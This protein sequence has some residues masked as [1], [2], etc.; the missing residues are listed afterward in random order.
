VNDCREAS[1]CRSCKAL[2]IWAEHPVKKN[3]K[4]GKPTKMP[5]DA[6][7]VV[8]GPYVLTY[9]PKL[10]RMEYAAVHDVDPERLAQFANRFESHFRTCPNAA[11]HSKGARR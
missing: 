7:P 2:V 6:A 8:N 1:E 11:Q 5:L 4:T 10:N 3:A 9:K